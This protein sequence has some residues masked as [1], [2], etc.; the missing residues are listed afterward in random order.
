MAF[1]YLVNQNL[2]STYAEYYYQIKEQLKLV[3]W[4]VESSSDGLTFNMSSDIINQ[5][6]NGAGGM[7]NNYA[8]YVLSHPTLDGYKRWMCVQVTTGSKYDVRIK[9]AWS[10]FNS[11]IPSAIRAPASISERVIYGSGTDI[12]P[13]SASIMDSTLANNR[14]HLIF[15]DASEGYA[16]FF[17]VTKIGTGTLGSLWMM[18][19]I[20]EAHPLDIDPYIYFVWGTSNIPGVLNNYSGNPIEATATGFWTY[21]RKGM[22]GESIGQGYV[23]WYSTAMST[24]GNQSIGNLGTDPYDGKDVLLPAMCFTGITFPNPS[25]KGKMTNIKL[26]CVIRAGL[27]TSNSKTRIYIGPFNLPW[28][29]STPLI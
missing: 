17:F 22:S 6:A 11:G 7:N 18:E 9:M 25:Y 26:S 14:Y 13:S 27:D 2:V 19:K 29:G 5:S 12:S 10:P 23:S 8:W 28:N 24:A 3:G 20:S 4:T 1:T 15:G 16:F 21:T